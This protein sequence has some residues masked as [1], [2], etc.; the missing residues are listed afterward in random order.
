MDLVAGGSPGRHRGQG[1]V[2]ELLRRLPHLP[3]DPEGRH[4]GLRGSRAEMCDMDAVEAF[5]DHA[6][7]PEHPAYPRLA[8]R[9]ATSSSST[10]RPATRYYDELPAVVEELH[11][12]RSTRS[13]AP[14][15]GLFNYYGAPD[16]DRVIVAHGLHLR[17][18]RGSH[19]LPQR[20]RREGRPGQGSPVPSV[21]RRQALR[22]RPSPRPSKKIAVMDRTKEP[23]LHRRAALPWTSSPLCYEAGKTGIKVVGGRYGLG[24]KDTPPASAFAVYRGAQEG[25]AQARVHHRHR[26]R[27]DQPEPARGR[28]CAQHR[29]PRHHRVQVLGSGRRRYRR[30]QQELHQDHRR[31]HRQVRAGLLPVRLQ[32]DRR[33][34]HLATCALA[35]Q[36]R[37]SSPYYVD[38]GRLR[39]LPQPQLHRQGLQ[40]GPRRQAGRHLPDQL[41][42][43]RRGARRAHAR[44]G[45]ALH[46]EQQHQRLH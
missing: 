35:I 19:R 42:V 14:I 18:A 28:G 46:R 20:S 43:E 9:T 8:T 4:V 21:L 37:S 23:G 32:E 15:I 13:S 3:R 44:R 36:A 17:R 2:P 24:S 6:L 31:P 26:R 22:R 30:R 25:R 11:G 40:D 5:R 7:N 16:A 27:R 39:R 12:A 34:H 10:V 38:Q 41:P 29:S 1:P 45:Q 33:R